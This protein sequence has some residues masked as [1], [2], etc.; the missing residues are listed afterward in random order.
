MKGRVN[1]QSSAGQEK[2]AEIR[3]GI[4]ALDVQIS[5]LL[6]S[7]F[8]LVEQ[9]AAIKKDM[10]VP[11]RDAERENQVLERVTESCAS[12]GTKAA[13]KTLYEMIFDLSRN[14]Q[15]SAQND[16]LDQVE[17]PRYFTQVTIIGLGLI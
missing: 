7:R 10:G 16:D 17:A 4:D 8:Q 14:M 1:R 2:M 9:M 3:E 5:S 13:I 12:P 6:E 15:V 11:V